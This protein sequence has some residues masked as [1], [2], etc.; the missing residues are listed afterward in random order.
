MPHRVNAFGRYRGMK[1]YSGGKY[2]HALETPLSKCV[3]PAV[4]RTS[5]TPYGILPE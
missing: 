3:G 4:P 1:I 2:F 5:P